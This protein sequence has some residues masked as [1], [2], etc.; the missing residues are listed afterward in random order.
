[1]HGVKIPPLNIGTPT[2]GVQGYEFRND[3][4]GQL[5]AQR[6]RDAAELDADMR[7]DWLY[8]KRMYACM[9]RRLR[10]EGMVA[11]IRMVADMYKSEVGIKGVLAGGATRAAATQTL[12]RPASSASLRTYARDCSQ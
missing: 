4:A 10:Y 7:L 5:W 8:L 1:M 12:L 2:L 3:G 11:R 6:S 9:R